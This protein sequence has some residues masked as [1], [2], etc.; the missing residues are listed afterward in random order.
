[1]LSN[2]SLLIVVGQEARLKLF[3]YL[4]MKTIGKVASNTTPDNCPLFQDVFLKR[5][6][7]QRVYQFKLLGYYPLVDD[8]G[9]RHFNVL[10]H[11]L[12]QMY[13]RFY[14]HILYRSLETKNNCIGLF[15]CVCLSAFLL[16]LLF[17]SVC[18]CLFVYV[19]FFLSGSFFGCLFV[20]ACVRTS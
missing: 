10:K 7:W 8:F 6:I 5:S 11:Y 16:V 15:T 3:F 4:P 13:Y 1:M 9:Q 12:L 18:I 20:A 17:L 2:Y 14:F 19:S